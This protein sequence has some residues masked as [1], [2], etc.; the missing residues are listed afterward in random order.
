MLSSS[1]KCFFKNWSHHYCTAPHRCLTIEKV[2]SLSL[3]SCEESAIAGI[4]P[5]FIPSN[6][7]F[8]KINFYMFTF[9]FTFFS[10]LRKERIISLIEEKQRTE[11]LQHTRAQLNTQH[12]TRN[13]TT[14]EQNLENRNIAAARKKLRDGE[15]AQ[16]TPAAN[17]NKC[18]FL[19]P[20]A[21]CPP[22]I[23]RSSPAKQSIIDNR[24]AFP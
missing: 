20:A 12:K 13:E 6:I 23:Q 11:R 8:W 1:F 9:E 7:L 5:D 10:W 19:A 22:H 3:R 17:S 21:P 15:Q 16:N 4:F 14:S 2:T 24:G 18:R